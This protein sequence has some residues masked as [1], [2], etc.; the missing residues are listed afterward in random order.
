[1]ARKNKKKK[2]HPA[3]TQSVPTVTQKV[4]QKKKPPSA[5]GGQATRETV[6][7]L[8]IAFVLAFLFRTFQAEAFVIPTG[9]MAP[10]L[11]GQHKD[12]D[13]PECGQRFKINASNEA[14][15]GIGTLAIRDALVRSGRGQAKHSPPPVLRKQAE[16][17]AG[18]CPTCRHTLPVR[19]DLPESMLKN[20]SEVST[21]STYNGDRILVNKYLYSFAEPER[22]DVIVFKYPGNATKNYIKRLVGLPEE[23]L[24][25]A[26]GDVYTRANGSD[27]EWEIATKPP[28]KQLAMRQLVHDTHRDSAR[29]HEA[30]WP[31]R[32]DA[33]GSS[34][35]W[36]P[37]VEVAG[38]RLQS[39]YTV[40]AEE[41]TA[42]LRYQHTP[43]TSDTWRRVAAGQS[44]D[45]QQP[46]PQLISDYN[47]YNT[48]ITRLSL[49]LDNA[50][51]LVPPPD[52]LGLH[53]V[54]DLMVEADVEIESDA[55]TLSLELVESGRHYRCDIDIATGRATLSIL[56]F[57]SSEPLEGFAPTASTDVRGAGSYR[58]RF[59]Q[60]DD[61]LT[62]WVDDNV[63]AFDGGA[64][65][66]PTERLAIPQMSDADP[67]D[68]APV[69]IGAQGANIAIDR[70]QVW[71]DLY[72]IAVSS[73]RPDAGSLPPNLI[74]DLPQD[75]RLM[76]VGGQYFITVDGDQGAISDIVRD[77]G[78]WPILSDR[79]QVKFPIAADQFFVM[80]DNSSA[81]ADCR[82]WN[83]P[84]GDGKPGGPYLE[85]SLLIGKAVC[86][87]WPHSWNR[88]PG[89][90]IPF[91][92][93]P[94]FTDMRL[95]R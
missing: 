18:V 9:S 37:E 43:A 62:L 77:P 12:V 45:D 7:S 95:V 6:E 75:E 66:P 21:A 49:T 61:Q 74:V 72:Y 92:L 15:D 51:E 88:V 22:W 84:R 4:T 48:E 10:T 29:L 76:Q 8:V 5:T 44:V 69:A 64:A 65:F 70:L 39:R 34:S 26:G 81:S 55:G 56:P 82:I 32:W 38:D 86:V 27:D 14:E 53:W 73:E 87:Y 89:T 2:S 40:D 90:P 50:R 24:L 59:S 36:K 20:R 91:P 68:R 80:G 23:E 17:V 28:V 1:M 42:W 41:T 93:F 63:I 85:R 25:L 35:P 58:L 94:N 52:S 16:T 71:R 47:A 13:C 31:L 33:E 57:E 79:N 83:D 67:G 30:G 3:P 11:M 54:G 19:S 78:L 46:T 60:F